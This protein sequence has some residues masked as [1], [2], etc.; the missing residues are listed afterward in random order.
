MTLSITSGGIPSLTRSQDSP[1]VASRL[2]LFANWLQ[3]S[4]CPWHEPD[5][6]AYHDFLVSRKR[7][8]T[9][10]NPLPPLTTVSAQSHLSTVRGRYRW[11]LRQNRFRDMLLYM[12]QEIYPDESPEFHLMAL[13]DKI[14]RMTNAIQVDIDYQDARIIQDRPDSDFIRLKTSEANR[15]LA[16]VDTRTLHGKRDKAILALLL[17]TGLRAEELCQLEV[18]DLRQRLD[19]ELAL[20]V[21]RGKRNKQRLVPYGELDTCL[22]VVDTWLQAAGIQDGRVFRALWKPRKQVSGDMDG[23]QGL[24]ATLTYA[25]LEHILETYQ[26]VING[27]HRLMEAHDYRRTYARLQ[28]EAGVPVEV[29]Q[30]NLGHESLAT[31]MRY[32]GEIDGTRRRARAAGLVFIGG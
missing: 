26:P 5:F 8:D 29:I 13:G 27:Q 22:V 15:L 25:G 31:T 19:G 20:L 18:S 3:V 24:R 2:T 16:S 9:N 23:E 14:T 11:L 10:G 17:A 28:Y 12:I 1:S 7:G 32:I 30:V 6:Q 21:K 4:G